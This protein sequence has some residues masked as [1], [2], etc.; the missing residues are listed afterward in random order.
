MLSA[1]FTIFTFMKCKAIH[2]MLGHVFGALQRDIAGVPVQEGGPQG[3]VRT[4]VHAEL[5]GPVR[6]VTRPSEVASLLGVDM[7]YLHVVI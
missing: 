7:H 1:H 4:D 2:L 6:E 5:G 3:G